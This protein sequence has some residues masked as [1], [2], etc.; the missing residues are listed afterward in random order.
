LSAELTKN[1]LIQTAFLA[2]LL[3]GLDQTIWT[4]WSVKDYYRASLAKVE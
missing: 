3:T 1:A 4:G 2:I